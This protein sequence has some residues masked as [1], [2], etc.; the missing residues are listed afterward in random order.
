MT[1]KTC[2]ITDMRGYMMECIITGV[3]Q[4]KAT[5]VLT[6]PLPPCIQ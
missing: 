4:P 5:H 3:G 6:P 1:L 2:V